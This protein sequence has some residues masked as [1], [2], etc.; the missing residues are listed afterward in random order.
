MWDRYRVVTYQEFLA[1][2]ENRIEYWSMRRELIPGLLKAKPNQAHHALAGL[3]TDGKLHTVI[4]QNIDGL[5]Q[6]AGN[7]NVIELHGTNMTAS[8]LSCGKQWSIDEIQ[9]RLEGG[10]LDPLCDRCNGLI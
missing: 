4:T 10:D 8:C 1:S 7:T 5:H 3:E 6:A 2:H 9:L